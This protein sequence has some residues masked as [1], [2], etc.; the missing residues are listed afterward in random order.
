MCSLLVF[1]FA[2]YRA[3]AIDNTYFQTLIATYLSLFISFVTVVVA[4]YIFH[5]ERVTLSTMMMMFILQALLFAIFKYF[6]HKFYLKRTKKTLL[7][8]G[9]TEDMKHYLPKF[10]Q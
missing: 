2:I 4:D 3:T 1:F 7:V 10:F 5:M 9:T 6:G 8:I